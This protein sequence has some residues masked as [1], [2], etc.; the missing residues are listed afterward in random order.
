[1]TLSTIYK[2]I[3]AKLPEDEILT[4]LEIGPGEGRFS[5]TLAEEDIA[6]T[7]VDLERS[8]N[9]SE[10]VH[11][12]TMSFEDYHSDGVFD[13]IHARNVI[14]FFK[15]KPKQ[16]G[17][18][19]SMGKYV[20]ITFFGPKDPWSELGRTIAKEEILSVLSSKHTI[21]YAKEEEFVGSTLNGD[22]KPWHIFTYLIQTGK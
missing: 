17:R 14:P 10:K 4:V 6:V 5:N 15:D 3:R 1:M 9:I 7:A 11:F 18:M 13:L 2:D 22:L 8:S 21:L 12:E 19:L 20:Y 16:L